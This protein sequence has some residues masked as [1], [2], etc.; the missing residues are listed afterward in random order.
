MTHAE[1]TR[2]ASITTGR[3]LITLTAIVVLAVALRMVFYVGPIASDDVRYVQA[4]QRIAAGEHQPPQPDAALVRAAY[5]VWL[6]GW[7]TCGADV[8]TLHYSEVVLSVGLMLALFWLTAKW[9]NH[10]AALWATFGLACF[11]LDLLL[12]GVLTPDRFALLVAMVSTGL[13][14]DALTGQRGRRT[15]KLIAAGA[16][17]GIA[18]SAKELYIL[19]PI[20]YALWT[21]WQVRPI[22]PAVL[23][24]VAIAMVAA[25]VFSLEFA[26]FGW[27]TGDW[28]YRAHV[29]TG[30][31]GGTAIAH[32]PRTGT[33]DL[34]YYPAQML[35]N[36]GTVGLFGW[37]MVIAVLWSLRR[38]SQFALPLLWSLAF[39]LFLQYGPVSKQWRYMM[40]MVILLFVVL[41]QWLATLYGS[42]RLPKP[43]F[44]ATMV[45][46]V[47]VGLFA[48]N[49]RAAERFY[50]ED[51]PRAVA[52]IDAMLADGE[53]DTVAVPAWVRA[54]FGPEARSRIEPWPVVTLADP[55][56]MAAA[57]TPAPA[58][59]PV[60]VPNIMW[61]HRRS[62][63]P[64]A[65]LRQWLDTTARW[66]PV[67]YWRSPFDR[68]V[69][70]VKPLR[71]L[72]RRT[73]IGRLYRM[74]S[75]AVHT[76]R[77]GS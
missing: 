59:T 49:R 58:D 51:M 8:G 74:D 34:F 31:Y 45:L 30:V 42:R 62:E 23:R 35:T 50:S 57:T 66:E 47:A 28:L 61:F 16:L 32:V 24:V 40:P 52:A 75:P 46:V 4:A 10:R 29:I 72:A 20:I 25:A 12:S 15:L 60:L 56:A 13:V 48:A 67:T 64:I 68:L 76:A 69:A 41:G 39:F 7:L 19:L 71:G 18:A 77:R 3:L 6:A 36:P 38:L 54:R 63:P 70:Q 27:W 55:I 11:P 44:V 43:A 5:L 21:L 14:H 33:R 1:S 26:F 73:E 2:F 65:A 37:L 22:A 17:A 9:T 53:L